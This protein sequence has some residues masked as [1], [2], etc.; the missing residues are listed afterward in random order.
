M[1][2]SC[3][4]HLHE[5]LS[6]VSA[7]LEQ[8]GPLPHLHSPEVHESEV[9]THGVPLYAPQKQDPSTQV[10]TDDKFVQFVG[11]VSTL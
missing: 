8:G 6:Q 10:S 4:P 3:L 7:F 2:G 5:P 1:Q 11:Q 9:P